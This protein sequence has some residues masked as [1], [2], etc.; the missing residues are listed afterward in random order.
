M[1]KNRILIV[2]NERD[3]AENAGLN[4]ELSGYECTIMNDGA[5][6]AAS[7]V[8]DS[9][10]DLALIDV[11]LP[12]LDGLTLM[13]HMKT[14]GIPVLYLT[15]KT[16]IHSRV[17][18]LRR[19]AEDYIIKPFSMLELIVRVEKILDRTG[20]LNRILRYRDI[21]ADTEKRI[22]TKNGTPIALQPLEFDIFVLLLRN[23]DCTL[24]RD[25]IL[26]EIWGTEYLTPR[27]VDT[28]VYNL[29]K[30]LGLRKDIISVPKVGYRLTEDHE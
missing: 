15:A 10:Y 1:G 16:D 5:E 8:E 4:L 30:K 2:E 20:K 17:M 25:R 29:R 26:N 11:T 18:G 22:V 27:T 19:G 3:T 12:G 24:S 6:A 21:T 28:H 14:Y 9:S 13:E 7:L 23:T